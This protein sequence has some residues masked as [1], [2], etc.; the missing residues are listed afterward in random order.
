M[1]CPRC[2]KHIDHV[3]GFSSPMNI[4]GE[5]SLRMKVPVTVLEIDD[6]RIR[7]KSV[8]TTRM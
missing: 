5:E 8:Q 7:F 3:A 6:G 2:K 1:E 4:P